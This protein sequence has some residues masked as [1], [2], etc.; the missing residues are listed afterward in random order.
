[1]NAELFDPKF[2]DENGKEW[3]NIG[4]VNS[5]TIFRH[6]LLANF[7][8]AG[9][10]EFLCDYD[11]FD[12][13]IIRVQDLIYEVR[14]KLLKAAG[15]EETTEIDSDDISLIKSLTISKRFEKA[16]S[17]IYLAYTSSIGMYDYDH[18]LGYALFLMREMKADVVKYFNYKE[19]NLL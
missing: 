18:L 14:R 1:M 2:I 13:D 6:I 9:F 15:K 12:G 4:I 7:Y 5:N 17:A 8:I 3:T 16:E 11:E 19:C 10:I